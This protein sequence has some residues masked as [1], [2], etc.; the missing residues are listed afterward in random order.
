MP[1][2]RVEA[3][4]PIPES[5]Q[6]ADTR[7]WAIHW[8][9]PSPRISL[10]GARGTDEISIGR[11]NDC[12]IELADTRVSRRHA[13][14]TWFDAAPHI[15]DEQSSNGVHV[16]GERVSSAALTDGNVVRCGDVV[17]VVVHTERASQTPLDFGTGTAPYLGSGKL[18]EVVEYAKR[19]AVTRDPVFIHAETGAG[20]EQLTRIIHAASGR[21][22][23]F[24]ALNCASLQSNLAL[25]TLFGHVRGAFTS[26]DRS[27]LGA[28]RTAEHGTLFLDEVAELSAEAQALLLRTAQSG[29]VTPVG[30]T[31]T[32]IVDVRIVCATH[33]DLLDRACS[34]KFRSD[35]YYRL[36]THQLTLPAL[37][38]RREDILELFCGV[39]EVARRQL[40]ASVV[41]QLLLHSWPGNIREL[42]NVASALKVREPNVEQW[43]SPLLRSLL[44]PERSLQPIPSPASNPVPSSAPAASL[45][46][47]DWAS[48]YERHGR[49]AARVATATGYSVSTVKRHLARFKLTP[50]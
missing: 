14:I 28:V 33:V 8:V 4:D 5:S 23:A 48:L 12:Q 7:Q 26:A 15:T 9:Y 16:D 31:D 41:E 11:G 21:K 30:A 3:T 42:Q 50:D 18:L 37:R 43:S 45:E 38:A 20:K 2:A 32:H 49:V 36:T 10:I 35:L 44:P 24:V 29:E 6:T 47:E 40:K 13:T 39:S 17:G 1:T 34:G 46:R 22:G 19:A 25:S 27:A